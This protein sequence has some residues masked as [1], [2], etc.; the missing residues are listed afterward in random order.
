M[1]G[2]TLNAILRQIGLSQLSDPANPGPIAPSLNALQFTG[3]S[4]YSS[5]LAAGSVLGTLS[6]TTPGSTLTVT[7]SVADAVARS[8]TNLLKGLGSPT[9]AAGSTQTFTVTVTE[10]LIGATGSPRATTF[11]FTAS[12]PAAATTTLTAEAVGALTRSGVRVVQLAAGA[13]ISG[14]NSGHFNNV[15]GAISVSDAGQGN[16][17]GPYTFT[18]TGDPAVTLL[19]IPVD[20][21]NILDANNYNEWFAA[22]QYCIATSKTTDWTIMLRAGTVIDGGTS[23]VNTRSIQASNF[24]GANGQMRGRLVTANLVET[25]L[26]TPSYNATTGVVSGTGATRGRVVKVFLDG[27]QTSRTDMVRMDGTWSFTIRPKPTGTPVFTAF[28]YDRASFAAANPDNVSTLSGGS[29]TTSAR[30]RDAATVSTAL[31]FTGVTPLQFKNLKFNRVSQNPSQDYYAPVDA[32]NDGNDDITT[33]GTGG[34]ATLMKE[35]AMLRMF[36]QHNTTDAQTTREVYGTLLVTDCTFSSDTTNCDAYNQC[37]YFG[38]DSIC[39]QGCTFDKFSRCG[40]VDTAFLVEMKRNHYKRF[41]NDCWD[42]YLNGYYPGQMSKR[43]FILALKETVSDLTQSVTQTNNH[44]DWQQIG[45]DNRMFQF[46]NEGTQAAP[47]TTPNNVYDGGGTL[48]QTVSASSNNTNAWRAFNVKQ[49]GNVIAYHGGT[50]DEWVAGATGTQWLQVDKPNEN[51]VLSVYHIRASLINGT[52]SAPRDWTVQGSNDGTNWTILDTQT[53]QT[54]WAN[55]ELRPFW[56]P[57]LLSVPASVFRY[58]RLVVTATQD[59]GTPVAICAWAATVNH[60]T[61]VIADKLFKDCAII[62]AG[63]VKLQAT[64]PDESDH[65]LLPLVGHIENCFIVGNTANLIRTFSSY[66]PYMQRGLTIKNN[67]IIQSRA[68]TMDKQPA[69]Y[70][71]FGAGMNDI[72]G[73][74]VISRAGTGITVENNILPSIW[75]DKGGGQFFADGTHTMTSLGGQVTATGN[76]WSQC[77][78]RN[79]GD[80]LSFPEI[81]TNTD[82]VLTYREPTAAEQ[83]QLQ[84]NRNNPNIV[85]KVGWQWWQLMPTTNAPVIRNWLVRNFLGRAAAAGKGWVWATETVPNPDVVT[86]PAPTSDPGITAVRAT[87]WDVDYTSPPTMDPVGAPRYLVASRAGYSTAGVVTTYTE[88]IVLTQ[89]VRQIY[90]NHASLD[91]SRVALADYIYS[92][93]TITGVTNN[94]TETSPLPIARLARPDHAVIGNTLPPELV[95]IVA[96]HRNAR[97]GEQVACVTW[98]ATDGTTTVTASASTAVVSGHEGDRQ[99]VLVYRPTAALDTSGFADGATVT[100]TISVYPWIGGPASV[101]TLT[102]VFLKHAA[103]FASPPIAVISPTGNDGSGI[104]STNLTTAEATPFATLNGVIAGVI[105]ARNTAVTG[106]VVDGMRVYLMS[107]LG[108]GLQ[109]SVAAGTYQGQGEMIV[110]RHPSVTRANAIFNYGAANYSNRLGYIRFKDLTLV[111]QGLFYLGAATSTAVEAVNWN[112]GGYSG[113]TWGS[114]SA[115]SGWVIGATITNPGA[116]ATFNVLAAESKLLRGLDY[117][118]LTTA[119]MGVEI[120]CV[121]GC[122]FEN[123]SVSNATATRAV[124]NVFVGFN[125]FM[126]QIQNTMNIGTTASD[127]NGAAFVQN[128]YE[129]ISTTNN[130]LLRISSDGSLANTTHVVIHHET[131]TGN[132]DLGRYNL[133]YDEAAGTSRRNHRLWSVVGVLANQINV[134]GDVF[135]GVQQANADAPN[136]TGHM[137]FHYGVG[138]RGLITQY[139]CA[140][141]FANGGGSAFAQAYSGADAVNAA[142]GSSINPLWTAPAHVSRPVS[143]LVAGAGG[144]TYTLQSGSPALAKVQNRVVKFDLAGTARPAAAASGAYET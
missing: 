86:P 56:C 10:T 36:A 65:S 42:N 13:T 85:A 83:T 17:S 97:N 138:F 119:A 63:E 128:L 37:I 77:Y 39:V 99:A 81:F 12:T 114:S 96:A 134:K 24:S 52:L 80:G 53:N 62:M 118:T 89:R 22:A 107:G 132:G 30:V 66:D 116:G 50:A 46:T 2:P 88:N 15:A 20:T 7:S 44:S 79:T 6:G 74:V 105:A 45:V 70:N 94:S 11:T 25:A 41:T 14:T 31:H 93:D 59:A 68:S 133:A 90:P 16:L 142:A 35:P 126:K 19:T 104:I 117:R 110:T 122:Y 87:G 125:R 40:T 54:G 140:D 95:E 92:T 51:L 34:L 5:A 27:V 3:S 67:T 115:A 121:I 137:A 98:S 29:L 1:M 108:V 43:T 120:G 73:G 4:T 109:A 55:G 47:N 64:Q 141:G 101:R 124:N 23:S 111:R 131:T 127:I 38:G 113:G 18:V 75:D 103:K 143:A 71:S 135:V 69:P 48:L 106:S 58:K 21:G 33:N 130:P 144:G 91:A 72:A 26:P 136:R 76:I 60:G 32:N 78:K 49:N 139:P 28:E 82:S 57:P 8:G 84:I 61:T 123:G 9:P 100:V 129:Y 112:L 102:A